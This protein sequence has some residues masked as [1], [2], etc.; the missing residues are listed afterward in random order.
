MSQ[1][2]GSW[3]FTNSLF[4]NARRIGDLKSWR[5]TREELRDNVLTMVVFCRKLLTTIVESTFAEIWTDATK[6]E[7]MW[8][9]YQQYQTKTASDVENWYVRLPYEDQ[10]A[11]IE[12]YN[13]IIQ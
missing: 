2:N 6:T 5:V 11:I 1:N 12:W 3:F 13:R 4:G 8:H 7:A 10:L 9:T